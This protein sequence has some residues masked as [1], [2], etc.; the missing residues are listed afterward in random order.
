MFARALAVVGT[1]AVVGAIAFLAPRP[2]LGLRGTLLLLAASLAHIL[3]LI[4]PFVVLC[5]VSGG[6]FRVHAV[7]KVVAAAPVGRGRLGRGRRDHVFRARLRGALAALDHLGWWRRRGPRGI[8]V[9]VLGTCKGR[10]ATLRRC[11]SGRRQ[12]LGSGT[13]GWHRRR[14]GS[15]GV[16]VVA[17]VCA[18]AA[19]SWGAPHR[20]R[21]RRRRFGLWPRLRLRPHRQLVVYLHAAVFGA[22]LHARLGAALTVALAVFPGAAL[23]AGLA[24]GAT[25][26]SV[27]ADAATPYKT[28]L[29]AIALR[30]RLGIG[31]LLALGVGLAIAHLLVVLLHRAAVHVAS[32]LALLRSSAALGGALRAAPVTCLRALCAGPGTGLNAAPCAGLG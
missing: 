20:P 26:E 21:W 17:A 30:D 11:L 5:A 7:E 27:V 16:R 31:H 15:I 9:G 8:V 23:G 25:C 6:D 3:V 18:T 28:A 1:F 24:S 19:G 22:G 32:A 29:F 13:I 14:P 10:G 2:L 12:H 4:T